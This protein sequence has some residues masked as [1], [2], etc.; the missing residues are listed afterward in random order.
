MPRKVSERV[1][2]ILNRMYTS[3]IGAVG[4]YMDMHIRTRGLYPKFSAK[5]E[6]SAKEEMKHAE[7]LMERI[8]FLGR[9]VKYEKHDV[10]KLSGVDIAAILRQT[11][12]ME[13]EAVESYNEAIRICFEDG[14]NGSRMLFEKILLDEER[15][16]DESETALELLEKY[17]DSYIV[18]HY[19]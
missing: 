10:P 6:E 4:I 18:T 11:I 7:A 8:D 3:E 1:I 17:G 19:I 15:H 14:D 16:L 9:N 12:A 5:L 13:S 2:A